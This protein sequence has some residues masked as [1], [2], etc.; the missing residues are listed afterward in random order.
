MSSKNGILAVLILCALCALSC[1][2]GAGGDSGGSGP[3]DGVYTGTPSL[4]VNV[5]DGK[6]TRFQTT[7]GYTYNSSYSTAHLDSFGSWDIDN[8]EIVGMDL[9]VNGHTLEV[10]GGFDG[11]DISLMC[12]L[13]ASGGDRITDFSATGSLSE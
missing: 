13:Y 2:T 4:I 3:E 7:F 8:M 12:T 9:P 10:R 5:Q 6:V 1:D 11:T